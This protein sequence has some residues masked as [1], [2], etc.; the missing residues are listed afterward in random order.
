MP[1][2]H[3]LPADSYL[4]VNNDNFIQYGEGIDST[5]GLIQWLYECGFKL[6]ILPKPAVDSNAVYSFGE[7]FIELK[8]GNLDTLNFRITYTGNLHLTVYS[9]VMVKVK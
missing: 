7:S 5:K 8:K 4:I 1:K 6:N 9:G 2:L 3:P